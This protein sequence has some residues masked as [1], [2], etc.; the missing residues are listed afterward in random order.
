MELLLEATFVQLLTFVLG[1]Q[2]SLLYVP[3]ERMEQQQVSIPAQSAHQG[4]IAQRE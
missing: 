1:E 3:K 4:I 2:V